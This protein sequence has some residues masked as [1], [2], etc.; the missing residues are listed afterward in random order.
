MVSQTDAFFQLSQEKQA[1]N[2]AQNLRK[3]D[4]Q[5]LDAISFMYTSCFGKW[6]GG[7]TE[8]FKTLPFWMRSLRK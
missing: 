7:Q 5:Y 8:S 6:M 1:Q 3:R 4:M 2:I